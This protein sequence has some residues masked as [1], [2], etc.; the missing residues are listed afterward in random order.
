M[1]RIEIEL[2][3]FTKITNNRFY[4]LVHRSVQ[5]IEKCGFPATHLIMVAYALLIKHKQELFEILSRLKHHSKRMALDVVRDGDFMHLTGVVDTYATS[6]KPE[7]KE[8]AEALLTIFETE[9]RTGLTRL[10]M[11]DQTTVMASVMAFWGK[12]ENQAHF[13]TLGMT[14]DYAQLQKSIN[15]EQTEG[16]P[17]FNSSVPSRVSPSSVDASSV[18]T[19]VPFV[20]PPES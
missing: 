5:I 8:A 15:E 17:K 13:V 16:S 11:N 1:E 6:R 19:I 9:K 20:V 7:I 4:N 14:E 3:A 18:E 12:T 2:V 10:D